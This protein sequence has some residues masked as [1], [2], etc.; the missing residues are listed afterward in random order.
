[1]WRH[2][3][4]FFRAPLA[5]AAAA[6]LVAGCGSGDAGDPTGPSA[7]GD[8]P[9][10]SAVAAE[11]RAAAATLTGLGSPATSDTSA[12]VACMEEAGYS[13]YQPEASEQAPYDLLPDDEFR[14]TYGFGMLS[15]VEQQAYAENP[16]AGLLSEMSDADVEAFERA[17]VGCL[18]GQDDGLAEMSVEALD[19]LHDIEADVRA[20]PEFVEAESAWARCMRSAEQSWDTR[21]QMFNDLGTEAERFAAPFLDELNRLRA[22]GEE[23]RAAGLRMIDVLSASD[24]DAYT[25]AVD[26]EVQAAQADHRCAQDLESVYQVLWDREIDARIGTD[27]DGS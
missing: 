12:V 26:Q 15:L 20:D 17:E 9:P 21:D 19:L 27:P 5:L 8:A 7:T 22:D 11:V 13:R 2:N 14:G 23:E 25:T 18:Q 3:M 6:L 1:M 16:N 10:T 24:Y 4:N